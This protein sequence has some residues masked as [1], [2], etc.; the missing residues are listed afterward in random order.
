MY[1]DRPSSPTP[2]ITQV[3]LL[4]MPCP[5]HAYHYEGNRGDEPECQ[6][7]CTNYPEMRVL[8]P[9]EGEAWAV[10]GVYCGAH[11][12]ALVFDHMVPRDWRCEDIPKT[13]WVWRC[14]K[15]QHE[16][17]EDIGPF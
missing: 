9:V 17:V 16:D 2:P 6:W 12:G 7:P 1:A 13:K 4:A 5:P 10:D 14:V 3:E 15:C 8:R 11:F